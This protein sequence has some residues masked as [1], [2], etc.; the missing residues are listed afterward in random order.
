MYQSNYLEIKSLSTYKLTLSVAEFNN[1]EKVAYA[2]KYLKQD[3][4]LTQK[5]K[6]S[7][8][9]VQLPTMEG[10][11]VWQP[12]FIIYNRMKTMSIILLNIKN[13]EISQS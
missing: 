5:I 10:H 7:C 4:N 12:L 13:L 3:K 1:G 2:K 9:Q 6:K 8:L 11:L